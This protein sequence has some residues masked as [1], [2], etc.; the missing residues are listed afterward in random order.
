M[1]TKETANTCVHRKIWVVK[2][3]FRDISQTFNWVNLIMLHIERRN[4]SKILTE[5]LKIS[6]SIFNSTIYNAIFI[7]LTNNYVAYLQF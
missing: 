7:V 1:C 4:G 6:R 3:M 5:Q 2:L